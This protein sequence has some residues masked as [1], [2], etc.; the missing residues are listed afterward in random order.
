M[1]WCVRINLRD[2]PISGNLGRH[3]GSATEF[4]FEVESFKEN[5][6]D[7][8][9]GEVSIAQ[10]LS[11]HDFNRRT[12]E[13]RLAVEGWI[14]DCTPATTFEGLNHGI[15]DKIE[16]E[17]TGTFS[18]ADLVH[19]LKDEWDLAVGLVIAAEEAS[20]LLHD[21]GHPEN[22]DTLV[23]AYY[24]ALALNTLGYDLEYYLPGMPVNALGRSPATTRTCLP[25]SRLAVLP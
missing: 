7:F 23:R 12:R 3:D 15:Y 18:D 13:L 1:K 20:I 24:L 11:K 19:N 10:T 6:S 21:H 5:V 16:P 22:A 4:D 9:C 17:W 14:L 2:R 8:G 25:Y